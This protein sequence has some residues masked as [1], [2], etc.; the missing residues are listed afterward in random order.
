MRST[1]IPGTLRPFPSLQPTGP[2]LRPSHTS[3]KPP[4]PPDTQMS[5]GGDGS[6]GN[7]T[8][9]GT[10]QPS[11]TQQQRDELQEMM[12]ATVRTALQAWSFSQGG[13]GGPVPPGGPGDYIEDPDAGNANAVIRT[14][15]WGPEEIVYFDPKYEGTGPV[16]NV[17]KSVF[18]RDVYSFI[19]RLQDMAI[20]RG[21]D[22]LQTV[23]PQCL[24]GA[25]LI[26]HSTELTPMEKE[27]LRTANLDSWYK[28]LTD[29]F[30]ERTP[31]ALAK[32]QASKYTMADAR[33]RKDPRTFVQDVIRYAKAANLTSIHNQLSMAWNNLEWEFRLHITEPTPTTTIAQFL[34]ELDAKADM[35]YE[36]ARHRSGSGSGPSY[37]KDK[38]QIS[39]QDRRRRGSPSNQVS[40]SGNDA[41]SGLLNLLAGA[42]ANTRSNYKGRAYGNY[43]KRSSEGDAKPVRLQIEGK[44]DSSSSKKPYSKD[45]YAKDKD[46]PKDKDKGKGRGKQQAYVADQEEEDNVEV[47]YYDPENTYEED[48]EDESDESFTEDP[49]ANL[50]E[51][52]VLYSPPHFPRSHRCRMCKTTFDS[53]NKLHRH[54]RAGCTN[55]ILPHTGMKE[56]SPLASQ[57]A[58]STTRKR[59]LS[60]GDAMSVTVIESKVDPNKD[61]GT[62]FGFR[63]WRY[64]TTKVSLWEKSSIMSSPTPNLPSSETSKTLSSEPPSELGCLDTGA[65]ITIADDKFFERQTKGL[66]PIRTMASPITVRGIGTNKHLTDKY[67]IVPISL[68]GKDH[69]GHPAIA[70]FR[71]EVHL[72]EHLKANMLLGTDILGPEQI[73]IDLGKKEAIIG[74]CGVNVPIDIGSR[75][76]TPAIVRAVHIRK[77]TQVPPHSALAVPIHH[78]DI[79]KDRDYLFEPDDVNF[80]LYAHLMDADTSSVLVRNDTEKTVHIPR[81]FRLGHLNEMDY[82]NACHVTGEDAEEL[83]L[84]RPKREHKTSWFKKLI[85][86]CGAAAVAAAAILSPTATSSSS[87]TV[88][89]TS[90]SVIGSTPNRPLNIPGVDVSHTSLK[91]EALDSPTVVMPNGITIHNSGKDAIDAFA[92]V[93]D[94]YPKIWEDQG[95]AKLPEENWMTIPL[96][97]DWE[98]KVTGKVKIYPLG[99]KDRAI[100]NKTFDDLQEQGRLNYTDKAT[101]FR[102]PCFVVWRPDQSGVKK[103]RVVID[104]RGL[105]AITFPDAYPLPLQAEILIAVRDC[106]YI[107]VVD[108]TS[109][110]YQWRVHPRDRH[111]LTVVSH[112]GQESF[113]R[114]PKGRPKKPR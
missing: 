19:D 59:S 103:G 56:T 73:T 47:D 87:L 1:P 4:T 113:V 44:S 79:P 28:Y 54:V 76:N 72:V 75:N 16:V 24:R 27:L 85:V 17:G 34:S 90:V 48:D 37:S 41:L 99:T 111:K 110:F 88:N 64:A 23:L 77:T 58:R 14:K 104:I 66:V 45:K 65:G 55:P 68:T 38:A 7:S 93:L 30:K 10:P 15:G 29:R 9:G 11:F 33:S 49:S 8:H 25:A 91:D 31:L 42:Q 101:P 26:W 97:S 36:M 53:N 46:G 71:R 50:A 39:K 108:C 78:L 62:G 3:T 106:L 107:S 60:S 89:Q 81:N 32:M 61:I 95:F 21:H 6:G 67:A 80:S 12:A 86:A 63:G 35:W 18:Y 13:P 51:P 92:K 57:K 43:Q 52:E 20:L 94:E 112:R 5:G 114:R 109:F 100:L 2:T 83:A 84:R 98:D 69:K 96:K 40:G 74:S 22:K 102:Y 105:N 70:R 82:P